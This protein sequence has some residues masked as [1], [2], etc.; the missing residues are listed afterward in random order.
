MDQSF[1]Q[2]EYQQFCETRLREA[3]IYYEIGR[4]RWQLFDLLDDVDRVEDVQRHRLIN[5]HLHW[6]LRFQHQ[7]QRQPLI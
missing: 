6:V 3:E 5:R 4:D 1:I 7:F 2:V